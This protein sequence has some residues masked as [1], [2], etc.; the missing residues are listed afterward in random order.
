M[1]EVFGNDKRQRLL[2]AESGFT[3]FELLLAVLL[4][5]MVSVMIY[6]VLNVGIKFTEKGERKIIH[7]E[8]RLSLVGLLHRQVKS[9]WYDGHKKKVVI[10]SDNDI[11]RL[12]TQVSFFYPAAGVVLAV[13]RFDPVEGIV[14]YLEKRDFYN[15][16][17]GD[18]YVPDYED[19]QVLL[20]D[21]SSFVLEYIVEDRTVR[22]EFDDQEYE[23]SPWC[24]EQETNR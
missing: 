4:L 14:Y 5:A 11:F 17:Y 13:Y 8:R 19:M 21:V 9:A 15:S 7:M 23:F 16:D 10:S 2:T 12:V 18:E 6:S 1:Q 3:L 24:R 22:L 20:V